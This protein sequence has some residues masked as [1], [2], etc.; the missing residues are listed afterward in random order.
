M[1]ETSRRRGDVWQVDFEPIRGHE[2]GRTR[3]AVIVSANAFNAGPSGLVVV[4][5]L[6]TRDRRIR[7]HVPVEPPEGGL[8]IRSFVLCDQVRTVSTERLT[9]RSGAL[10]PLSMHR[11]DERLRILLD[12]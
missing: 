10:G 12:L 7:F 1:D 11:I 6:T 9:A 2:Q 8:R 3:P 4:C 5:P